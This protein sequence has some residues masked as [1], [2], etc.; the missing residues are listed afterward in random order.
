MANGAVRLGCNS[1]TGETVPIPSRRTVRLRMAKDFKEG[2]VRHSE[3]R[4]W[5]P[6]PVYNKPMIYYPMS[7][8]MLSRVREIAIIT[9]P[10]DMWPHHKLL[11]DGSQ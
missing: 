8:F 7:V 5:Y 1:H 2:L 10:D 4:I 11:G 3:G 6:A 9:T